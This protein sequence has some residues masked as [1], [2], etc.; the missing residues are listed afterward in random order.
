MSDNR[1]VGRAWK[2]AGNGKTV[3]DIYFLELPSLRQQGLS[4]RAIIDR[5]VDIG[6]ENGFMQVI[7]NRSIDGIVSV[8][9]GDEGVI[10]FDG[11]DWRFRP[12]A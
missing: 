4:L 9:F 6:T 10:Y 3:A 2:N 8:V 11:V 1:A 12:P 7:E 5:L